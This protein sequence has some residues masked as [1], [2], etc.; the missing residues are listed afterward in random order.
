MFGTLFL[1]MYWPS[2]NSVLV[3]GVA[4]QR[5]VINTLVA[6]T[7]SVCTSCFITLIFKQKLDMEILLRATLAG[8][9]ALGACADIIGNLVFAYLIG[10]IAGTIATFGFFL[11]A[12]LY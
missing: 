4:Q 10:A 12:Y 8:G 7:A 6:L 9:V 11:A 1:F 5:A 2:F 3:G